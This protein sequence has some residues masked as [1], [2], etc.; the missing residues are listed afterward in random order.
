VK[1]VSSAGR[2]EDGKGFEEFLMS[3]SVLTKNKRFKSVG[4]RTFFLLAG[5]GPMKDKFVYLVQR[6]ELKNFVLPGFMK[7]EELFAISNVFVFPSLLDGFGNLVLESMMSGVPAV[8][9][10]LSGASE[11]VDDGKDALIVNPRNFYKLSE[12]IYNLLSDDR[13]REEISKNAFEKAKKF[14]IDEHRNK[15]FNF[16]LELTGI[17]K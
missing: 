7:V 3:A 9:S 11:I 16:Y 5:D 13:K 17:E 14:S 6:N 4:Q 8:V 12:M 10:S 1:V 2:I 15:V